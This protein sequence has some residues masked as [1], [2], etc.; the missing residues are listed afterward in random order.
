[1][2]VYKS[3]S[4]ILLVSLVCT[5]FVS[6]PNMLFLSW[7]LNCAPSESH[8]CYID[9]TLIRF[10]LFWIISM[11]LLLFNQHLIKNL[12]I[13]KCILPNILM[14][15][16]AYFVYR[17][18]TMYICSEFDGRPIILTF[19]FF[20]MGMM[21]QMLGYTDYLNR[22]HQIKE[23]ELQ[24]MKIES[25]Q[26]RCDAL[27]NQINP[28][29]FFNS[30]NGI[31][32]LVRKKDEK[33]TIC[34]IDHLSDIFRYILQSE[35]KGLVTLEE[36]LEFARSFS[37]V[38]QVRYAG[39]LDVSIDVAPEYMHLQIPVLALLPLIENVTVHNMIDSEHHMLVEIS[40]NDKQELV[41]SNPLFP[42]QYKQETHGTGLRNLQNRFALLMNTQLKVEKSDETFRV[43]LPLGT[44]NL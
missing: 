24:Q 7:D 17:G 30:L 15:I 43:T 9:N 42:K 5:I 18:I 19:Q 4:K 31:S 20:V 38:M 40:M 26:S 32:S 11:G 25:L 39:K 14:T 3:L 44:A 29:F 35:H 33:L 21:G 22:I 10:L 28:H 34:Y 13:K 23:E 6:Y 41:V 8:A 1:M 2:R 12:E 36:E 37:Q 16:L 27:T